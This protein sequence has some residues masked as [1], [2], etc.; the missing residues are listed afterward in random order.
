MGIC[1]L[2][3]CLGN[4][5]ASAER[6]TFT[7]DI[8]DHSRSERILAY[9]FGSIVGGVVTQSTAPD[10]LFAGLLP[11]QINLGGG[12]FVVEGGAVVASGNVPSAGTRAN[13][14]ARAQLRLNNRVSIAYWHWSNGELGDRNPAVDSIGVTVRLRNVHRIAGLQP[15]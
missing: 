11:M 12:L 10:A 1:L 13:F 2:V 5:V 15:Q 4:G 9:E 7:S 8:R 3:W 6:V 14:M